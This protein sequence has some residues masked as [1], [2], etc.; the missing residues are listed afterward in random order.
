MDARP[1]ATLPAASAPPGV[2]PWVLAWDG[3][4]PEREGLLEALCALGNGHFVTRGAA[5]EAQADDVRYPGTYV[6][7]G[8]NRLTSEVAG[9]TVVNEDLVNFPN[10]LPLT[11]RPEDGGWLD[12]GSAEILSY[13]QE[14]HLREGVLL[15]RFRFRDPDGRETSVEARRLVSMARPHLAAIDYRITPENWGGD[16]HI[17]SAIDGS[18]RNT[19]VARYRQLANRHLRVVAHGRVAPQGV[20]L[21][22]RTSQSR[23]EV[24]M[25]ARMCVFRGEEPLD[26]HRHVLDRDE[27]SIREE[28]RLHATP[29]ETIRV[30]KTVALFASNDR[31]I[32]EPGMEA[33]HAV[34]TAGDFAELLLDHERAWQELWRRYDVEIGDERS[35]EALARE[36]VTLRLYVFQVLQTVS[37]HTVGLDVGAPARGLHGEAY[38]GHVFWD[39]LFVLPF[40]NLRQPSITRSLLLYR[41]YR[42][43][44]ARQLAREAGFAGAMYPWQSSHDGRE[45]TQE[46][47]LNPMSGQW[48]PDWS[49]L[50]R[51]VDAAIVYNTWRYWQATGDREFLRDFGAEM[52][53]EIARFWSSLATWSE[54]RGRYE[55]AGV[56]GPDEYHEKYPDAETGGLRNNAYTNVAAAWCLLRALDALSEVG[57][58][59]REALLAKLAITEEEL[60]RWRDIADRM[61]VPFVDGGVLEQFEGY[62]DLEP[63]DWKGYRERYGDIERLDRI[64]KAEG[65]TADR[66]QVSKQADAMMLF[67]LFDPAPLRR[68]LGRMGYDFGPEAMARTLDYYR[69]RTSHGSTLSKLVFASLMHHVDRDEGYR[70]FLDALRADIE[71]VQGGT[72]QEG[73]HL[74]LMAGS[75]GIVLRRYAGVELHREGVILEPSLPPPLRRIRCRVCWRGRWLDVELSLDRLRV[76]VDRDRPEAVPIRVGGTWREVPSDGTVELST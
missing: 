29:G 11:F 68:L 65:D 39:E 48:G 17:R 70:L 56:M 61:F 40:Y 15:R 42:L 49:H 7:G 45:A 71:D 64:L 1:S 4:D 46:L 2:D 52:M 50:Q 51:H 16:L 25:A 38:R 27:D 36:Q 76:S 75:V 26:V 18:V 34:R 20:Y 3:F 19:G 43:D 69:S 57:D 67:Y 73:I 33:R 8:Y 22:A 9:R 5:E 55:I 14:L 21:I 44:S 10:W 72:T 28:V 24:A 23:F 54:A 66:Y 6:A 31:G 62:D 35:R 53:L 60:D 12:L 30:E 74:G 32:G 59:R 47:H 41:Y 13:R 63:F 37:P 58:S